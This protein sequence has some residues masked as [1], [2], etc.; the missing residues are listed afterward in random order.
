MNANT[1]QMTLEEAQK[2]LTD[3]LSDECRVDNI[4]V[5]MYFDSVESDGAVTGYVP[6]PDIEENLEEGIDWLITQRALHSGMQMR[7]VKDSGLRTS[8]QDS[9]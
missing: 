1:Q 6:K 4:A 3:R 9:L 5:S 7:A 2:I 8:E